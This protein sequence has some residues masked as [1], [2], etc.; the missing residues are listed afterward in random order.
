MRRTIF[1]ALV[2]LAALWPAAASAQYQPANITVSDPTP[3]VGEVVTVNGSGFDPGATVTLSVGG[4][5]VGSA[6]ADASGNVSIATAVPAL[7]NGTY[8][9]SLTGS[10]IGG[11]VQVLS[12]SINVG[13]AL[14]Q[15]TTPQLPRTGSDSGALTAV[16]AG[17]IAAGGLL[18]LATRKRAERVQS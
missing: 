7:A 5:T 9:V 3:T 6:V 18:V 16:A 14:Q 15:T 12:T 4:Q 10:A 13:G 2:A 17:L 1:L 11:Q 8:S